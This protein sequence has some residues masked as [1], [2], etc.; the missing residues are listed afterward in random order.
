MDMRQETRRE[1]SE[2]RHKH[3]PQMLCCRNTRHPI[4]R[5]VVVKAL[6]VSVCLL[7]GLLDLFAHPLPAGAKCAVLLQ[8]I[9]TIMDEG[10]AMVYDV[11]FKWKKGG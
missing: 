11:K 9:V 5:V 3:Y 10:G 8:R 4:K 2:T 6:V 1:A 7:S